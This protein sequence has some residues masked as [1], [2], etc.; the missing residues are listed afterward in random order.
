[1]SVLGICKL[2]KHTYMV[3]QKA[4]WHC[5]MQYLL[6]GRASALY[7]TYVYTVTSH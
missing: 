4:L 7:G 3:L 5:P 6:A 2:Q 1:M